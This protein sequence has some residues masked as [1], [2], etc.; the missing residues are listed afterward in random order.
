MVRP[1]RFLGFIFQNT[2]TIK[3]I[4]TIILI[5]NCVSTINYLYY[6]QCELITEVN[7][8]NFDRVNH[9]VFGL[10]HVSFKIFLVNKIDLYDII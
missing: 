1:N 4:C 10:Y 7:S 8:K 9:G 5:C 3:A 6:V 2:I